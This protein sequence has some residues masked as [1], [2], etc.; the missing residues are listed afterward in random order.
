MPPCSRP[1]GAVA[2][3]ALRPRPPLAGRRGSPS[4]AGSGA[5]RSST[6]PPSA[7]RHGGRRVAAEARPGSASVASL[8]PG[9]GTAAGAASARRFCSCGAAVGTRCQQSRSCSG[10]AGRPSS[11]ATPARHRPKGPEVE[12]LA[13]GLNLPRRSIKL[14]MQPHWCCPNDCVELNRAGGGHRPARAQ[15]A[16]SGPELPPRYQLQGAG[17]V[18]RGWVRAASRWLLLGG[19]PAA[20]IIC[21][22]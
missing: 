7:G 12:T 5:A 10:S 17:W 4:P 3:R 2:W 9:A 8:L 13:S 22:S 18:R 20:C 14:L 1:Q 19:L 6:P 15:R 16:A 21:A 11:V